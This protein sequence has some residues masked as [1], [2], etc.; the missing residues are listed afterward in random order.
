MNKRSREK[1]LMKDTQTHILIYKQLFDNNSS[2]S[3][4]FLIL[5]PSIQH[6]TVIDTQ[7]ILV[8]LN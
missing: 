4:V 2:K 7:C 3:E 6:P 5:F 8:I 1:E